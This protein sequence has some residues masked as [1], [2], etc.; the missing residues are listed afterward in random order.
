MPT[1]ATICFLIDKKSKKLLLGMKKKGFGHGKYNGFGGKVEIGESIEEAAIRELYE[2]CSIKVDIDCIS[3][4]AELDF[5]FLEKEEWNQNVHVFVAE[6]WSGEP[7]E[8]DEMIPEWFDYDKIPFE[9]MWVDDIHWIPKIL[10]DKKIKG[11]FTFNK[12]G[13]IISLM[14]VEEYSFDN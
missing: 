3:K 6:N 7:K 12:T 5:C 11:T 10:E 13:D 4:V 2:E 8:S 1:I 9:N 14:N